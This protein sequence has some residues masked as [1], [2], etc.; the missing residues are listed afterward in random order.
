MLKFFINKG[1]QLSFLKESTQNCAM[2]HCAPMPIAPP[3]FTQACEDRDFADWHRGCPWCAVWLVWLDVAPLHA[4]V[5]QAR[6]A[7]QPWLL[8][9]YARQPHISVAYR[10][11]MSGDAHHPATEFATE[12]LRADIAQL[13]DLALQPWTVQVHGGDSF[14]TV[15]YLAVHDEGQLAALHQALSAEPPAGWHYVPHVTVGHYACAAPM[16]DM[17]QTL[18][19]TLDAQPPL[20]ATVQHIALARYRTHDIAGPLTLEGCW[21][22]RLQRYVPQAGALLRP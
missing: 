5:T 12:Q 22:V 15:P 6:A 14:S 16:A 1:K 19:A 2:A 17:V 10:G 4:R 13:H 18:R 21:D 3:L 20:T 8:P 7:L 11:L 9:R